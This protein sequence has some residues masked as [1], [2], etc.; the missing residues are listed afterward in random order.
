M[1]FMMPLKQNLMENEIFPKTD[2]L[3]DWL[4]LIDFD[5]EDVMEVR[6]VRLDERKA[7]ME[8]IV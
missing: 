1:T 7:P 5:P 8:S 2:Y 4:K 3:E 6:P